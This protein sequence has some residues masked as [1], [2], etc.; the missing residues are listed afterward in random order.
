MLD[1]AADMEHGLAV[2]RIGVAGADRQDATRGQLPGR[3]DRRGETLCPQLPERDEALQLAPGPAVELAEWALECR[4]TDDGDGQD[5]GPDIP[6]L[7][8]HD[9]QLHG[10]DSS[11]DEWALSCALGSIEAVYFGRAAGAFRLGMGGVG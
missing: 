10:R 3:G 6:R 11:S 2:D 5:V 9:A 4:L 1:R 7:V 8:G